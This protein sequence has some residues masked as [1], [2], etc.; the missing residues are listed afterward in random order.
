MWQVVNHLETEGLAGNSVDVSA[1]NIPSEENQ[2]GSEKILS[3][4]F[5][6]I[7]FQ[8]SLSGFIVATT[9]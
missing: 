7:L 1:T 4:L 3:Y 9:E 2:S 8:L 6:V 5:S